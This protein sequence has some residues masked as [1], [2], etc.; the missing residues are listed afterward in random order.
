MKHIVRGAILLCLMAWL[1]GCATKPP[2]VIRVPF[3][4]TVVKKVEV[5]AELLEP[6]REPSLEPLETTKDLERVAGEAVAALAAC[7]EDKARIK[8]WQETNE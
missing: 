6:C 3:E 5:P 1:T 2:Q 7:S 8:E 4:T